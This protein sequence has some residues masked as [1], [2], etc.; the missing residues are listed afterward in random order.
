MT[1]STCSGGTG[2]T[3]EAVNNASGYNNVSPPAEFSKNPVRYGD[4]VVNEITTD[5]E[6]DGFGQAWG[7]TRS[8]TNAINAFPTASLNGPGWMITQLP[9]LLATNSGNTLVLLTNG[10]NYRYFDFLGGNWVERFYGEEQLV[11]GSPH[12]YVFTDTA[13]DQMH[14]SDFS[15]SVPANQ[16]GQLK[17]WV[18]PD[19]NTTS[20]ISR[21]AD[22]RPTEVQR[23]VTVGSTTTTESLLYSY[24]TSSTLSSVVLR[25]QVNGGSWTIIRQVVYTYYAAGESH[26]NTSDLKLAV[27]EDASGNALDTKYYRY[28]VNESTG[29]TG[30]LKYVFNAQ[31]YARLVAALGTNVGSLSDTQ[32][33]PY[34]DNYF[35][36]DSGQRVTKETVQGEGCSSCSGGQG[37]YTYSYTTSSF[38]PNAYNT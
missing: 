19:G 9:Y 6:S 27:I 2:G 3:N 25:R 12:E 10:V 29:Y 16:Q 32:V 20:V 34:A 26:G 11:T 33:A 24:N 13:G 8:W 17:S 28:Y 30:G 15:Q 35:E 18:D 31:S 38:T 1:Y 21:T 4:G 5:L 7:Q 14:F 22:G 37:T 36:F 23:S